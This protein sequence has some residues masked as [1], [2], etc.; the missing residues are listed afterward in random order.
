M[1]RFLPLVGGFILFAGAVAALAFVLA[2]VG[3][4]IA[5]ASEAKAAVTSSSREESYNEAVASFL[6][7]TADERSRLSSF[8]VNDAGVVAVIQ[9]IDDAAKREKVSVTIDSVAV[10]ASAWNYFDPLDVSVSAT[11]SFAALSAFATDLESL[12]EASRLVSFHAEAAE[13]K[14][15]FGSYRVEFLKTKSP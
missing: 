13:N 12:P 1:N 15:W 8:I 5:T 3:G 2:S 11:G 7:D 10:G 6:S 9:E 14:A 4:Y